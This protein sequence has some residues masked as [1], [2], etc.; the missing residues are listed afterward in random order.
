MRI[1][2]RLTNLNIRKTG[3]LTQNGLFWDAVINSKEGRG[4]PARVRVYE[5]IEAGIWTSAGVFALVDAW[6]EDNGHKTFK[7]KLHIIEENAD[8]PPREPRGLHHNRLIPSAIKIQVWR[9]DKGKCVLC[10]SQKNL[11]LDHALPFSDGGTSFLA[12]SIRLLCG[13][14]IF[15]SETRSSEYSSVLGNDQTSWHHLRSIPEAERL[16]LSSYFFP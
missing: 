1:R 8:E 11:H 9:R 15:E 4:L 14:T 13:G 12:E 6:I 16:A 3:S 7:F 5:K 10:G 2:R